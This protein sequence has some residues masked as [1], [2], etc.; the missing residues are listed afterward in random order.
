[1]STI[2]EVARDVGLERFR[3]RNGNYERM[4]SRRDGKPVA[5]VMAGY[6][7]TET[8]ATCADEAERAWLQSSVAPPLGSAGTSLRVVDLFSGCGGLSIGLA[9]AAR[10]L[11]R[12]F[13]PV[14][15]V[16]LDA[17]AAQTYAANFPSATTLTQDVED[18]FPD[19]SAPG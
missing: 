10:A 19:A 3:T 14:L 2:A 12:S 5:S 1:M 13:D 9:E 8:R 6:R 4:L 11:N 15:A 17:V 18:V 7:G 16:D